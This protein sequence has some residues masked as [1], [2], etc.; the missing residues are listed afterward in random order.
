MTAD[1]RGTIISRANET[2]QLVFTDLDPAII[3]KA[4]SEFPVE[5]DRKD[6]LYRALSC[7]NSGN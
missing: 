1:P 2:E 6:A 4:R 7:E 5:K 3:V